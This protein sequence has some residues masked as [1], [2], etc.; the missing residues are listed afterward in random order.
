MDSADPTFIPINLQ[1]SPNNDYHDKFA[2]PLTYCS[3]MPQGY[4]ECFAGP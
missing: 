3:G 4:V 2:Y 1:E